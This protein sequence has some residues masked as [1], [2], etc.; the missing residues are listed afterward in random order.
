VRICYTTYVKAGLRAAAC[1]GRP[2]PDSRTARAAH[3]PGPPTEAVWCKIAPNSS[4]GDFGSLGVVDSPPTLPAHGHDQQE[5]DGQGQEHQG[6]HNYTFHKLSFQATSSHGKCRGDAHCPT[7]R[8]G[9]CCRAPS[10]CLPTRLVSPWAS[11]AH[12][13]S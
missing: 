6:E 4:L 3:P 11:L 7:Q 1:G 12:R 8:P 10:G 2:R 9:T 5:E 13:P